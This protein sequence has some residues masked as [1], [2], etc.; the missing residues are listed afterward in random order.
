MAEETQRGG[1]TRYRLGCGWGTGGDAW[2]RPSKQ[3]RSTTSSTGSS[4]PVG[5]G[6]V[7]NPKPS[8][9]SC[10]LGVDGKFRMWV[11]ADASKNGGVAWSTLHLG[12]NA[13]ETGPGRIRAGAFAQRTDGPLDHRL[14][15]FR[16]PERGRS[17]MGVPPRLG[18]DQPHECGVPTPAPRPGSHDGFRYRCCRS[19]RRPP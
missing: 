3:A 14:S 13:R 17:A 10:S 12:R 18:R 4:G 19:C 9:G 5:H 2:P 6:T 1:V 8:I 11:Y 7:Q 16:M 15:G